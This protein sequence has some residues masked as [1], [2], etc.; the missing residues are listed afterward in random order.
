MIAQAGV[1]INGEKCEQGLMDAMGKD[2]VPKQFVPADGDEA[3]EGE[4]R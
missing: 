3:D 4:F 2:T 1:V